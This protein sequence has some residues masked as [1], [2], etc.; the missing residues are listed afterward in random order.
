LIPTARLR[1]V[2][3]N[4]WYKPTAFNKPS[5]IE[6]EFAESTVAAVGPYVNRLL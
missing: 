6:V 5:V 1:C 4:P 3:E 2:G